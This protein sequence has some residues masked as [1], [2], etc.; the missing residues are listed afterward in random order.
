MTVTVGET[1]TLE[2]KVAGTPE[3][4]VEWYKDGKLLTSSQKHKFSFYNK[5]SSLKILSVEKE[6]AGT[7][8]FQVQNNVGKSSCTAVVDVSGQFGRFLQLANAAFSYELSFF[9]N[10]SLAS[11]HHKS[12]ASLHA[13]RMVPPSFTR[14]L[15][16]TGGVLGSSCILE[17][18]V[19]GSSPISIAWFHEKTKIVS[20]AKY[21]TTFSDNVCTLQLNSLDS[22]DMGSYTCVAANVA[23]S[24]ECRATLTVQG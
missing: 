8:T 23:G 13:D 18:K 15:K 19:A 10:S 7:Y 9:R 11:S 4:S 24:D 21:Q 3:L 14:R 20:G 22:S 16:D 12:F 5:M 6:D 1:C 17:C 2:C